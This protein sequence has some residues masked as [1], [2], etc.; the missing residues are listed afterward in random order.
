MIAAKRLARTA[1]SLHRNHS[2]R[3][4]YEIECVRSWLRESSIVGNFGLD[5]AL[6]SCI[7]CRMMQGW[8]RNCGCTCTAPMTNFLRRSIVLGQL[9]NQR[10]GQD[11]IEVIVQL[12]DVTTER[13]LFPGIS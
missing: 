8:R 9:I 12:L 13:C 1:P 5:H 4:V 3:Q 11:K 7:S 6:Y 2:R 10:A